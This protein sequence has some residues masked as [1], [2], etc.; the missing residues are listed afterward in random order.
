MGQILIYK[1]IIMHYKFKVFK[2]N[3]EIEFGNEFAYQQIEILP[4]FTIMY[5]DMKV[6][7]FEWLF[8]SLSIEF[9][10]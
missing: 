1:S 8:W 7:A 9:Y 6:I 3:I 2:L 10:K 5:G 4:R